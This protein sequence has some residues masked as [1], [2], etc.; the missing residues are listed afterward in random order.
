[1][2]DYRGTVPLALQLDVQS[3]VPSHS[4]PNCGSTIPSPQKGA[5][6]HAVVQRFAPYALCTDTLAAPLSHFSEPLTTPSP[7]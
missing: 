3:D 6:V 2:V 4:S 1:V 5:G 7:Q